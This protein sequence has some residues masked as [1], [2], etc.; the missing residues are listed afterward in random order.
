MTEAGLSQV[1]KLKNL[2][3]LDLQETKVSANGLKGLA[4]LKKLK[5]LRLSESQ[6]SDAVLRA[7]R[8]RCTTRPFIGDLE[9]RQSAEVVG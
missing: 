1:A 9:R 5:T 8:N 7:A 6:Q 4:G 2:T 3:T